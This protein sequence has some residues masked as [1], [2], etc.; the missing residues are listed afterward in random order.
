MPIYFNEMILSQDAAFSSSFEK[1]IPEG[2]L[3]WFIEQVNKVY[4]RQIILAIE[5]S[6]IFHCGWE[7]KLYVKNSA[8]SNY[9]SFILKWK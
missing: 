9:F 6:L 8:Q 1:L 2:K 5:Y 7:R 3:E 4:L